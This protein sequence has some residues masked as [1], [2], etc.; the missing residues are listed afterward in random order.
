MR[1][2]NQHARL[3]KRRHVVDRVAH[4][5]GHGIGGEAAAVLAKLLDLCRD[6]LALL[7]ELGET[8][9]SPTVARPFT[10]SGF[11][12]VWYWQTM[13]PSPVSVAWWAG[14]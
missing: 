2:A 14:S 13:I 10:P 6:D 7:R 9:S 11:E 8:C 4:R 5:F 12:I 1:R 3:Q